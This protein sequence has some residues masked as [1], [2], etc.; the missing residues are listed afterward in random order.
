MTNQVTKLKKRLLESTKLKCVDGRWSAADGIA[1][2]ERLLVTGFT[3][4]LQCWRDGQLLDE[5]DERDGPLPD[6]G[7]LNDQVPQEE[8]EPGLDGKPRPPWAIVYAVYLL[9]M[10][11]DFET[12]T[13][14]NSTWGAQLAYERLT[15]RL[16]Q[17]ARLKGSAV[18]AIVKLDCR[19]MPTKKAGT[20]LR[21]EFT[22]LEW[23]DL[24][25]E[26]K[27]PAQL[28]P[29][30]DNDPAGAAAAKPLAEPA[31]AVAAK[32]PAEKKKK[33]EVGKPVEPPTTAEELDD[34][35]PFV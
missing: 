30:T 25:E 1:L 15:K 20:K 29:P 35:I 33:T 12:F 7:E 11:G 8:W 28:P 13:F 24:G 26:N 5:L 14:I 18:T 27:Q 19:P 4:G 21:P 32:P 17:V 3:R 6:V 34:G 22:I 2:P 16:E 31:A 10:D 23:R 9:S